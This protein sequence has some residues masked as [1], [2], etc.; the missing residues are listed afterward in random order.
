VRAWVADG[1]SLLLITDHPP[2]VEAAMDLGRAFGISFRN[3]GAADSDGG[4]LVF[5]RSDGTLKDHPITR[6]IEEVVTFTGSSFQVPAAGQ[7]LLTFGPLVC[8][9]TNAFDP[10]PLPLK[11]H[12]QGAVL[13]VG[14]GRVAVF[15]EAAMFSAQVSGPNRSPIGMNVPAA[16]Q[17]A[18]FLL[19][20]MHWLTQQM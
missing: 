14:A 10:K 3:A 12:L 9:Y 7:P 18:Q 5:R 6:G 2:N 11:G 13:E 1:G 15:A 4:R 16:K 20:V 17:N 19:N 8:S